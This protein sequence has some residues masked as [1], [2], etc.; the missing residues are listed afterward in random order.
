MF[1]GKRVCSKHGSTLPRYPF[2]EG[3]LT[4][5]GDCGQKIAVHASAAKGCFNQ[6][7]AH[8]VAAYIH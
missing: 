2:S 5:Y 4:S 6:G 3:V 1:Q 8:P 7:H